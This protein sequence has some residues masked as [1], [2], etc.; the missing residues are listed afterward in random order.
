MPS[1]RELTIGLNNMLIGGVLGN[2]AVR[3]VLWIILLSMSMLALLNLD[4]FFT[5]IIIGLTVIAI[6]KKSKYMAVL[7]FFLA[8]PPIGYASFIDLWRLV[9]GDASMNWQIF[10]KIVYANFTEMLQ[11]H[12]YLWCLLRYFIVLSAYLLLIYY[13]AKTINDLA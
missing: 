6:R 13:P 12:G 8:F 5:P 2:K 7:T 10:S 4:L 11:Y 1:L 9:S 3:F